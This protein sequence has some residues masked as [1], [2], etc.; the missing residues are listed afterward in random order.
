MS[1]NQSTKIEQLA[2]HTDS[3]RISQLRRFKALVIAGNLIFNTSP[4]PVRPGDP[5]RI[6][7]VLTSHASRKRARTSWSVGPSP[8][9][10][11]H[12]FWG[13]YGPGSR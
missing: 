12:P 13:L 6:V 5:P 7:V 2:N 1:H 10:E 11:L 9:V 4:S 3:A 8:S